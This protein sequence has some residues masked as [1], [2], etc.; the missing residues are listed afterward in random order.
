MF[1]RVTIKTN[2]FINIRNN[3]VKETSNLYVKYNMNKGYA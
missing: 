1:P 3:Y 2:L